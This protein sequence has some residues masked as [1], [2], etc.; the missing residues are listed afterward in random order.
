MSEDP[1]THMPVLRVVTDMEDAQE[2]G[3]NS[4]KL[5]GDNSKSTDMDVDVEVGTGVEECVEKSGSDI[6]GSEIQ[7]GAVVESAINGSTS[8]AFSND[9]VEKALKTYA[10]K[11]GALG[12]LGTRIR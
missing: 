3:L 9:G 6:T 10:Y 11:V 12:T 1:T 7:H 2:Q 8:S 5:T 4:E